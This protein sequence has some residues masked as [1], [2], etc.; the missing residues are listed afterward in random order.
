MYIVTGISPGKKDFGCKIDICLI[1]VRS[2]VGSSNRTSA[3]RNIGSLRLIQVAY[4]VILCLSS[5]EPFFVYR[6]TWVSLLKA[7]RVN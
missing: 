2:Q 6:S 4:P 7:V 3:A 5:K 1:A